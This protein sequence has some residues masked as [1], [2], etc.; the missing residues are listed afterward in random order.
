MLPED[1][2]LEILD[3]YVDEDMDEDFKP[4]EKTKN[5]AVDNAGTRVSTLGK[6]P[7]VSG[8]PPS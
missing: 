4:F 3:F 1:V 7:A 8:G 6:C 5:R 2:L